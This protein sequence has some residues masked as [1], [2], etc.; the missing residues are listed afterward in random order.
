MKILRIISLIIIIAATGI[1]VVNAFITP[2]NTWVVRL[3]GVAMFAALL[4]YYGYKD[5]A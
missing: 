1:M 5:R 2:M 3:S 4:C